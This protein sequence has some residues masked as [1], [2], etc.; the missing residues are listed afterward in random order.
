MRRA[1]SNDCERKPFSIS[2]IRSTV[3]VALGWK[4]HNST[5]YFLFQLQ[6]RCLSLSPFFSFRL[7]K[8][9]TLI[10]YFFNGTQLIQ[11]LMVMMNSSRIFDF[12]FIAA[13]TLLNQIHIRWTEIP[14][15]QFDCCLILSSMPIKWLPLFHPLSPF[16]STHNTTP[17]C[18][19]NATDADGRKYEIW[20][21]NEQITN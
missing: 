9:S 20:T 1:P 12:E 15:R 7:P 17:K 14:K 8:L 18:K 21:K 10:F 6:F 13:N 11:Y 19:S 3:L 16:L 4:C 2:S 5:L